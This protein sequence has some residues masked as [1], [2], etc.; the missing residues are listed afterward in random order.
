MSRV[1]RLAVLASAAFAA[2]MFALSAFAQPPGGGG[3]GPMGGGFGGGVANLLRV[4]KVQQELNLTEEQK[5]KLQQAIEKVYA[6]A[7]QQ[8]GGAREDMRARFQKLA[9]EVE[10]E[11]QS[12]LDEK[13]FLRLKQIELQVQGTMRSLMDPDVA[14]ALGLTDAQ[15]DELRKAAEE[16]RSQGGG[17]ERGASREQLMERF[18]D[19]QTKMEEKAKSI[20]TPEQQKKLDEMKGPPANIT[21]QDVMSAGGGRGGPQGGRGG[22]PRGG[23][24]RGGPNP[25]T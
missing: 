24:G 16:L 20:L 4:P 23:Q 5:T 3:R 9:Q 12:V 11:V 10:K 19:L 8:P 25:Q 22:R 13:Q 21:M 14:E 15:K 7:R 18:R 6:Q 17:L 1:S 2:G